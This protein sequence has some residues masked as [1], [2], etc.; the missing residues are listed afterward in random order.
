MEKVPDFCVE[1]VVEVFLEDDDHLLDD[2]PKNFFGELDSF[3]L[4]FVVLEV[5]FQKD[6]SYLRD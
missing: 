3:L 4:F 6:Y 1:V 2:L 5:L